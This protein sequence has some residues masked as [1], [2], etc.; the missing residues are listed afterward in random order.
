MD[1]DN[2]NDSY[3]EEF[4]PKKR[5]PVL[6][7]IKYILLTLAIILGVLIAMRIYVNN[8]DPKEAAALLWND[9]ALTAYARDPDHFSVLNHNLATYIS[10]AVSYTHLE[11]K[12]FL[13]DTSTRTAGAFRNNNAKA[14]MDD[15]HS[16]FSV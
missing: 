16:G 12:A 8:H 11:A 4:I 7:A 10:N 1:N 6:T 15:I 3:N 9:E 2:Y 14:R 5:G 13:R